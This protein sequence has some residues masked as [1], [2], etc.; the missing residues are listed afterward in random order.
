[1]KSD[2]SVRGG[3]I[4]IIG[5]GFS[6]LAVAGAFARYGIAYEQVEADS[7]LGGNWRHGVYDSVHLITSRRATQLDEWPMPAD[8]PD[9]PSQAQML[10]Y[11][12]SYA[13]RF[14]LR[15]SIEFN[16]QVRRVSPRAGG[17]WWV[18]LDGGEGRDYAG[19]VVASGHHWDR[20]MPS[21]PGVFDGELIHSRDYRCPETLRDKRVLVI[22]GGNSACDIAVEASRVARS[23]HISMRRGY[24]F[25]PKTFFGVPLVELIPPWMPMGVQRSFLR[26]ALAVTVG[27]YRKYGLQRPD[28]R[29]F[30]KHPTL[31]IELLQQ[32]R[33]G[34]I[35]AHPDVARFDRKEVEFVDGTRERIDIVVAATGFHVRFPFL[36]KEVLRWK[37]EVP[38]LVGGL[39]SP[40]LPNLYFL[41]NGQPRYGAGPLLSKGATVIAEMVR[42]QPRLKHPVGAVLQR[43]GAR[44]PSSWLVDPH[45]AMRAAG[46]AR[47]LIPRLPA[48]E[49]RIMSRGRLRPRQAPLRLARAQPPRDDEPIACETEHNSACSG[50]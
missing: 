39:V 35:R 36:S 29:I 1:M 3:K 24:W 21:Y 41:G 47:W 50:R 49:K 42:V 48:I 12:R 40:Q 28:H 5:A 27:D 46:R 4:L 33:H 6:G 37:G 8:W 18:E 38:E 17:R 32:L 2:Q 19:L 26:A 10:A 43:L 16:R 14:D 9:F 13:A 15:R 23:A 45:A 31:N 30:E 34:R 44:V 11:L 7:D 22:G 20:R 25:M